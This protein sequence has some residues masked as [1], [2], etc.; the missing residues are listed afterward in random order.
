MAT[1]ESIPADAAAACDSFYSV[2]EGGNGRSAWTYQVT[3][4]STAFAMDLVWSHSTAIQSTPLCYM[5]IAMPQWSVI[6]SPY[7]T[8]TLK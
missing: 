2:T 8:V 5:A 1:A 3:E 7:D 4:A 6:H